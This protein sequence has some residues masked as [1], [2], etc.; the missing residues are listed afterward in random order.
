MQ[1]ILTIIAILAA[2]TPMQAF[3]WQI[4]SGQLPPQNMLVKKVNFFRIPP[5][6][7]FNACATP[8]SSIDDPFNGSV[9]I[10]SSSPDEIVY[11]A[12]ASSGIFILP[13]VFKS[14]FL[15]DIDDDVKILGQGDAI[16]MTYTLQGGLPRLQNYNIT[17]QLS[18]TTPTLGQKF[19]SLA[20]A[21]VSGSCNRDKIWGSGILH[22]N[23]GGDFIQATHSSTVSGGTG[24]DYIWGSDEAD[25]LHGDK[26]TDLVY[27]GL[28]HDDESYDI[29][30]GGTEGDELIVSETSAEASYHI[31]GGSGNDLSNSNGSGV[32][33]V[34]VINDAPS[35]FIN[36]LTVLIEKSSQFDS[37][38]SVEY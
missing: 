26:G 21:K 33:G 30:S 4:P 20:N 13:A 6:K 5:P 38:F 17:I 31:D 11:D 35:T 19:T 24:D 22:G 3:S 16:S 12:S 10:V 34:E 1:K 23:G 8:S 32:D 36:A 25:S 28:H 37:Y 15:A 29:L 27:S 14:G 7:V 18:E 2:M 9:P